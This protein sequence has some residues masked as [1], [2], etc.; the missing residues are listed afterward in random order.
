M[1]RINLDLLVGYRFEK[2]S[3]IEDEIKSLGDYPNLSLC[4]DNENECEDLDFKISGVLDEIKSE[5][6][7]GDGDFTLFYINDNQ[8]NLYITETMYN[9]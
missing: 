2:L 6:G 9:T 3:H 4:L 5:E 7:N 1:E 8:G